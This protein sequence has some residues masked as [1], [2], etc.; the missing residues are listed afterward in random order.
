MTTDTITALRSHLL[1]SPDDWDARRALA[2]AMEEG[3][4]LIGANGQRFQAKKRKHP[5]R[6]DYME[7]VWLANFIRDFPTF[8]LS[9]RLLDHMHEAHRARLP[10][11]NTKPARPAKGWPA[12]YFRPCV[13]PDMAEFALA[14][15]LWDL[16]ILVRGDE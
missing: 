16:G 13:T 8:R 15:A 5:K 4:D 14:K 11:G 1:A 2:D 6:T 9:S 3:G 10:D 7:Y 12:F